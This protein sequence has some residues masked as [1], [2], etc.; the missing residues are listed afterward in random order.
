MTPRT[1]LKS[2]VTAS[3]TGGDVV[4]FMDME[5][6]WADRRFQYKLLQSL[7]RDGFD[8]ETVDFIST[9]F[10]GEQVVDFE[11]FTAAVE[12]FSK[13]H[14]ANEAR[15][16]SEVLRHLRERREYNASVYVPRTVEEYKRTRWPNNAKLKATHW[17][18]YEDLYEADLV[19]ETHRFVDP[20]TAIASAGSCFAA[21]ISRQ[22][23]YW[24]YNY[25]VEMDQPRKNKGH[26]AS[27]ASDP[28][29]C[30]A[31]YNVISMRQMVQRAFGEWV[32]EKMLLTSKK[33]YTDPFR[34]LVDYNSVEGYLEKWT[35]HN[36]ALSRAL[37]KCEVFILTLGMT[38]AWVLTDSGLAT[39]AS[40]RGGDATLFQHVNLT[41]ADN[42]RELE[43][44]Y[45]LFQR[46]NPKA[47]II[48]T[49]SPVPLNATF[50]VDR[51][52]VVAN[53]L[54]KSTLRVA[55]EEFSKAH[56]DNVFYFPSYEIVTS[57]TR[58]PWEID[59]RHVSNETIVRVMEHF[60]RM[61]M[62]D[63]SRLDVL[64]LTE[65]SEN[66]PQRRNPALRYTREYL[67]HP[68]KRY[69]GIYGR[70]FRSLWSKK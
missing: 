24:G 64:P 28:A 12:S 60:Q 50:N 62:V 39:S 35:E 68:V 23:Q 58:D 21:T 51:H 25:L 19:T 46:Y 27:F 14:G 9:V 2:M 10:A 31:L 5:N 6:L 22:L 65:L 26:S 17:E 34:T 16:M 13:D 41:V 45:D 37:T 48:T 52:V 57:A 15:K 43:V 53:G 61:F 66:F 69:L 56:P 4:F 49:V 38:E 36:A 11:S 7:K 29:A 47:K 44:I 59:M 55:L 40:P 20:E 1:A 8:Q 67:I 33:K 18:Y 42:V 3:A 30:G 70:S 32:P 54:S 63:Q